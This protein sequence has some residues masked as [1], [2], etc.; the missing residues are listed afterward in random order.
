V[1]ARTWS[2][3]PMAKGSG[4]YRRGGGGRGGE[5]ALRPHPQSRWR[6]QSLA[7]HPRCASRACGGREPRGRQPV[8]AVPLR[9]ACWRGNHLWS[10]GCALTRSELRVAP[11]RPAPQRQGRGTP[12]RRPGA[13][14]HRPTAAAAILPRCG[15]NPF[16]FQPL[17]PQPPIPVMGAGAACACAC[18][19]GAPSLLRSW[20]APPCP[21]RGRGR[22][23]RLRRGA[24]SSVSVSA[25]S[26]V[27][28]MNF[29]RASSSRA[30]WEAGRL[31]RGRVEAGW[32][33]PGRASGGRPRSGLV[34]Q[35]PGPGGAG[36]GQR[37]VENR[38]P[39]LRQA[40]NA[41]PGC[42]GT[43]PPPPPL[44]NA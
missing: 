11:A 30:P 15:R 10:W 21:G 28:S 37:A 22:R 3:D 6:S 39:A 16:A 12:G 34:R 2:K 19:C 17:Q 42:P 14:A 38:P 23:L 43:L 44:V 35:A 1:R 27:S 7:A 40:G 9:V 32:P 5:A 31:A 41:Q 20:P 26:A 25:S 4:C 13:R 8:A 29:F 24:Y 18:A 33:M 36:P